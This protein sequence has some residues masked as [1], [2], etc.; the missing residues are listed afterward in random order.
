MFFNRSYR[1]KISKMRRSLNIVIL[2][3]QQEKKKQIGK[4][5]INLSFCLFSCSY[6]AKK[7]DQNRRFRRF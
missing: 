4:C 6:K 2:L 7:Q 1:N 5:H 3:Y